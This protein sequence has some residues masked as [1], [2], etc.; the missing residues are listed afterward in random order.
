MSTDSPSPGSNRVKYFEPTLHFTST[1]MQIGE[2][3]TGDRIVVSELVHKDSMLI[4]FEDFAKFRE[5]GFEKQPVKAGDNTYFSEDENTLLAAVPGYPRIDRFASQEENGVETLVVSVEPLFRVTSDKMKA[6]LAVH[7]PLKEGRS[8]IKEDLDQLLAEAGIVYGLDEE[9]VA[10]A[11]QY[12]RQGLIEFHSVSIA[13]GQECGASQDAFLKFLIEIGPIAGKLMKDGSIDFRER[14]VMV[15]VSE[16]E[17][18][19]VKI[20][21][22]PGTAG[23]N[24]FGEKIEAKLGKDIAVK[25]S[26]DVAFDPETNEVRA[27]AGGVLSVVRDN[28]INVSS[29]KKIDSDIDFGTGNVESKNCLVIRGSVQPGFLV[30]AD[31]DIEIG[32]TVSSATIESLANIVIKGGITG[33]KTRIAA[34]GDVDIL[35][36]EQGRIDC[37]GNCVVRKQAYYSVIHAG[38]DIRCRVESTVVGSEMVAAG[39]MTFGDV[40]SEKANPLLLA[41]GVIPE[42][43]DK[44]REMKKS[45]SDMQDDIIQQLQI[46]GGRSRKLR[47][48]EREAEEMKLHLKRM[49]MIPG[50]GLYSRAGEAG[51]GSFS[52]EEMSDEYSIDL[53]DISIE[54]QGSIQ[55]GT[56]IQIGNRTMLLDKTITFRLFKLSDNLKRIL[57]VPPPRRRA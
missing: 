23:V 22:N 51:E 49:N 57:A 14:R 12:I 2:D 21:A 1:R 30:K 4:S 27:T 17:L 35:F 48:M 34:D 29:R 18:L 44:Y 31:G 10:G 37:G 9:K 25:T 19:A 55:A 54:V 36:I 11:K 8:L 53:R 32:G 52:A 43:L 33:Q 5:R 16:G 38:G 6:T 13:T 24:V 42:R 45:L 47:Q 7:P 26:G 20:P 15:P 28:I 40:G 41:A 50:S 3:G 46:G 39:S 56:T